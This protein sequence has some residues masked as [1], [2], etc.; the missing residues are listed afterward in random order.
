MLATFKID[1]FDTVLLHG[2]ACGRLTF[3]E[4]PVEL[5]KKCTSWTDGA[6]ALPS[7]D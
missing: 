1:S 2:T 4:K 5:A 6:A 3:R 7:P